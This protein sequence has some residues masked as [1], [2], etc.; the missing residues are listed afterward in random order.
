M[1]GTIVK[2]VGKR[3]PSGEVDGA[4]SSMDRKEA[5]MK[6]PEK[7]LNSTAEISGSDMNISHLDETR[8]VTELCSQNDSVVIVEDTIDSALSVMKEIF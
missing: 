1:D 7:P 2:R 5:R 8:Q 4:T 6:S 3:K